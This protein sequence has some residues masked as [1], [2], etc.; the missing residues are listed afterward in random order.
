M[1]K[2]MVALIGVCSIGLVFPQMMH[3]QQQPQTH[4]LVKAQINIEQAKSAA[5]EQVDGKIV[6]IGLENKHRSLVYDVNVKKS[7]RIYEVMVDASS[8]KILNINK[9]MQDNRR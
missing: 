1:K 9:Q 5:L 7:G 6:N 2:H 3:A 4:Q 8:G